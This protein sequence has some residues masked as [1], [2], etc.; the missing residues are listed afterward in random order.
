MADPVRIE[1]LSLK[2]TAAGS[3]VSARVDGEVIWFRFPADLA[4][5]PRPELF[6]P[7]ALFEA[8]VRGVDVD[9]DRATP[10][11]A[12]LAQAIP[13][14]QQVF[15]TW[16]PVDFSQVA[17]HASTAP[18]AGGSGQVI[19]CFSGGVDSSYTYACHQAEITHLLQVQ[20]FDGLKSPAD[21]DSAKRKIGGVAQRAGKRHIAVESNIRAFVDGRRLSWNAMHGSILCAL[22]A[23]LGPD[24]LL[25]P[26]SFTYDDL[27][28]WGSHP[29]LDPLWSTEATTIVHH[30]LSQ[31]RTQKTRY[32]LGHPDVLDHIQ[33]CWKHIDSNCGDCPKCVRTS[34]ALHLLGGKSASLPPYQGGRQL[35]RMKA[36]NLGSEAFLRDMIQ[37]A[38]ESGDVAMTRQL[39][40]FRKSFLIRYHGEEI[41][42]T[43]LGGFGRRLGRKLRPK[44][45]HQDRAKIRAKDD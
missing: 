28:P 7:P 13:A 37:L 30:G 44:E 24:R 34:L 43:L 19:C 21:W 35:D 18:R 15:T 14:I 2:Q 27:F 20:G 29:L 1:D 9:I 8:M 4:I 11:S 16:N 39:K 6:L 22:G 10:I 36:S 40:A 3:E 26:S 5:T 17:L 25:L 32:L 23:A 31:R 33:V 41:L 45:W 12:R 38:D 42:K